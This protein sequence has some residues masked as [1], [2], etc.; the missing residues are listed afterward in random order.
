M[1]LAAG[2][3]VSTSSATAR[4]V[5]TPLNGCRSGRST[6]SSPAVRVSTE[7][8]DPTSINILGKDYLTRREAAHYACVSLSNWD[9]LRRVEGIPAIPWGG[10]LVFRRTDIARVME[11][12]AAA[13]DEWQRSGSV[14]R[15]MNSAGPRTA[16]GGQR[17][18][19]K[20]QLK[21]LNSTGDQK[22]EKLPAQN[23]RTSSDC[24]DGPSF[25]P[26]GCSPSII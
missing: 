17:P 21:K 4:R 19:V 13:G 26:S 7:K 14:G 10:K 15:R 22:R 20:S 1:A 5:P 8:T 25:L 2:E 12:A 18:S 16:A 24:P 11:R 9:A 23:L 3:L 6:H